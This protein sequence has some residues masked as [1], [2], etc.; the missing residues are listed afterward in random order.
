MCQFCALG[1]LTTGQSA[2]LHLEASAPA[3]AAWEY[4]AHTGDPTVDSLI[5]GTY[6]TGGAIT[7]AAPATLEE[8][9]ESYPADSA[10]GFV[11]PSEALLRG[12]ELILAGTTAIPGGPMAR[13]G[14]VA[15][16][17]AASL[18]PAAAGEEATIRVGVADRLGS[19]ISTLFGFAV[20][21]GSTGNFPSTRPG[22][23]FQRDGD[24][25][26]NAHLIYPLPGGPFYTD[27]LLPGSL[28]WMVLVHELGHALGLSHPFGGAPTAGNPGVT[29]PAEFDS[30]E[31]TIMAYLAYPSGS[32]LALTPDGNLP[33][34]WMAH[35]IRALQH[36]YGAN[37]AYL[38]GDTTYRFDPASGEM[39]IDG[40]GQGAPMLNRILLTVW[41]GG[42]RDTYDLSN[43]GEGVVLDL[44]PGHGSV[45]SREQLAVLAE[46]DTLNGTEEVRAQA[47][48]W[49]AFQYHGDPRSLIENAIGGAGDDSITGNAG[50]NSL[51]GGEGADTLLAGEGADTLDGGAGDDVMAGGAGNDLYILR[52]ASDAIGELPGGGADTLLADFGLTL[53]EDFEAARLTETAG[54]AGLIGNAANN[55][56]VGNSGN[57]RLEGLTGDDLLLGGDG[58]DTLLAGAGRDLLDGGTGHDRLEGGEGDDQ[59]LGRDGADLLLGGEGHDDLAGHAGDDTLVGGAGIDVLDGGT[60]NDSMEGRAGDDIYIVDSARDRVVELL[61]DGRDGVVATINYWLPDNV[62]GLTLAGPAVSGTGNA[63]G[64]SI[65]GNA[66]ANR[67]DGGAGDDSL[68]GAAGRDTLRGGAD[69][70][71]LEGGAGADLLLGGAGDDML[72]ADADTAADRDTLL[73]G[74]GDDRLFADGDGDLLRGEAGNDRLFGAGLNT[75]DG[76]AGD[77]SLVG[78]DAAQQL[79]G[80][81]GADTLFASDGVV[82]AERDTLRGGAGDDAYDWVTRLD[83][84][85]ELADGGRDTV[86]AEGPYTLPSFVEALYLISGDGRGNALDNLLVGASDATRL[87]GMEG[88]DTLDGFLGDDTVWGGGGA[89][90]FFF[91]TL[92]GGR[93]VVMD[94]T[95]GEDVIGLFG[96]FADAAAALA[97]VASQRGVAVLV[98]P[99]AFGEVV[100]RGFTVASVTEAFFLVG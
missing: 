48:L 14:S 25:W 10:E 1:G 31:F 4:S 68:S 24:V 80:G 42:G 73:G 37:F 61:D 62:E 6:W 90:M 75:L 26:L 96:L 70:D 57:N 27:T 53:Q 15:S 28:A 21:P 69:N 40:V 88:G 97:A 7:Y 20:P 93:D 38:A 77:D 23:A 98:L 3:G 72:F 44:R 32:H 81:D 67:L 2:A 5:W 55:R 39:S 79:L 50:A 36:L 71:V 9:A 84:V 34:G 13:S 65:S 16:F 78:D 87:H 94:F 18:A 86:Y 41:D 51:S 54:G 33:Q 58:A 66:L 19:D 82:D 49:N 74:D 85:V 52:D 83:L 89:D 91:D 29:M 43:Y 8:W 60:G 99:E 45:F 76:G 59:L 46:A 100:L 92:V 95:P 47:N 56:L 22:D 11:P 35:D 64:N 17:V 30:V 63:V 12:I